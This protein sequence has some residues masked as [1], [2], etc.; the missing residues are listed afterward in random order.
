MN[1]GT[2][3]S[4]RA[5]LS[6]S[7]LSIGLVVTACSR[8]QGQLEG[9][10]IVDLERTVTANYDTLSPLSREG[11]QNLTQHLNDLEIHFESNGKVHIKRDAKI[12]TEDYGIVGEKSKFINIWVTDGGVRESLAARVENDILWLLQGGDLIALNRK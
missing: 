11:V 7:L 9:R 8:S 1:D 6:L 12:S 2:R 3:Y 10:W 4:M 5:V